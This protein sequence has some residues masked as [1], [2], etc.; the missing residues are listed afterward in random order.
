MAFAASWIISLGIGE[1][2]LDFWWELVLLDALAELLPEEAEKITAAGA[3]VT[4]SI[5]ELAVRDTVLVRSGGGCRPT[6]PYRGHG[7]NSTR[8]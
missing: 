1:L 4:V 6:G 3:T 5:G 7:P 8:R 2:M